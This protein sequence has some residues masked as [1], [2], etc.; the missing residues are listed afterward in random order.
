VKRFPE[1]GG[2]ERVYDYDLFK[3]YIHSKQLRWSYGA[4]RGRIGD[5]WQASIVTKPIP[6][7]IETIALVGFEGIY[8]DRFGYADNAAKLE[9][10]LAALLKV[11]PLVSKDQRQSFFNLSAYRGTLSEKY[12]PEE[13]AIKQKEVLYPFQAVWARGCTG[14]ENKPGEEYR[15]CGSSGELVINNFAPY[16]RR[17][18]VEMY[19]DSAT[20]GNMRIESPFFNEQ[21]KT[22]PEQTIPFSKT[23]DI[24]PGR[25]RLK[26]TS[27]A[28]RI[29]A[30]WDS[31]VMVFRVVNLNLRYPG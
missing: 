21:L 20:E 25:H 11:E 5:V 28:K 18:T 12:S 10:D 19:L 7:M 3:G 1:T 29:H 8:I 31:R 27:D 17:L 9:S 4:M 22:Y 15:W 16:T 6:E 30:P 23:F 14:T 13:L 24:P 2:I 26:F